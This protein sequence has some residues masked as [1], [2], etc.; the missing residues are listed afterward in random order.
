MRKPTHQRRLTAA[1]V[2]SESA[3][4]LF[5]QAA[6][7]LETAA[8]EARVVA[9]EAHAEGLVLLAVRDDADKHARTAT[10]KAQKIREFIK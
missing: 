2:R 8:A 4:S 5:E 9:D 6:E 7:E 3:L 1:T 10:E